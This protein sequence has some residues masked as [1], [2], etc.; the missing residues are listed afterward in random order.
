MINY[1]NTAKVYCVI[2]QPAP[3]MMADQSAQHLVS[4]DPT[5]KCCLLRQLDSY[6]G[7]DHHL[8]WCCGSA[9]RGNAY[10]I[11]TSLST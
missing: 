1:A 4:V 11:E 7:Q 8:K 5:A 10:L 3:Q 2:E 9:H 6:A